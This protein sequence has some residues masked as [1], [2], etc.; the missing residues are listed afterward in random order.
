MS[1]IL[2]IDDDAT[3]RLTLTRSLRKQGYEVETACDGDEGISLAQ[4][5][6]PSLIICDWM[7]PKRDGLE[8]CQWVKSRPELVNTYFILLTARDQEDD[9]VRGL[10]TGADDFLSKPPRFNELRARVQAGLRLH[11]INFEL[12][13]QRQMLENELLQAAVYVRSL[14]PPPVTEPIPIDWRYLPSVQL[15]GD[16]LDYF[17]LDK[18]HLAIY[19]LDV[20]G[21]GVGPALL[22]VSILNLLRSQRWDHPAV[23]SPKRVLDMLNGAFQMSSHNEMYFTIWFGVYCPRQRLLTYAC[24]GHPP[25]LLVTPEEVVRLKTPGLPIGII[26]DAEFQ[27]ETYT[28]PPDSRLYVFSDGSYEI[29]INDQEIWGLSNLGQA[30][31]AQRTNPDPILDLILQQAL[32]SRR[33]AKA[34]FDDDVSIVELR[35]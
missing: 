20:S 2:V 11:R 33:D 23:R 24:G 34:T 29:P 18:E 7:M 16:G 19:V 22:S 25:A 27:E 9:L 1:L 21:H 28:V 10:E 12:E 8:V 5:L 30:L 15:G 26:D 6:M 35:C 13:Q 14:L 3:T 32:Q 4:A 17:W 31:H